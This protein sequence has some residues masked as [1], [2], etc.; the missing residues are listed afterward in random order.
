MNLILEDTKLTCDIV[1]E[2]CLISCLFHE[3][4]IYEKI[5]D[6]LKPHHFF[7][8]ANGIIYEGIIELINSG[9]EVNPIS[10]L[11]LCK[12]RVNIKN[13]K[14]YLVNIYADASF[15]NAATDYTYKIIDCYNR[16]ELLKFSHKI[17]EMAFSSDIK[18]AGEMIEDFID[19]FVENNN[20]EAESIKNI[21]DK[22]FEEM[23]SGF[24]GLTNSL[25]TGFQ[26]I[27]KCIGGLKNSSLIVVGARPAMG[28]SLFA[29]NIADYLI[30]NDVN[31]LFF[32]LE[33]SKEEIYARMLSA[34]TGI[35]SDSI[36]FGNLIGE[37]FQKV[38]NARRSISA[39]RLFVNSRPDIKIDQIR[40]Q[41]RLMKRK[42][43]IGLI[44]VDYIQLSDSNS[45]YNNNRVQAISEISR[46]LKV[47]AKELNIPVIALSQLSR[48][49]ESREDKRPQLSDLRE[50]GA[51]EQDADV[52]MFL[53]R[54]A[55]YLKN[56]EPAANSPEYPI[57]IE[58][59]AK[60][61]KQADIIIAKNRF[62]ATG[63]VKLGFDG[64][65]SRFF[66]VL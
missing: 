31:V 47:I 11:N 15:L 40:S 56:K 54:E 25:S 53:H 21:E 66:D 49:N 13:L 10:V 19:N 61:E 38:H 44:I 57:W 7:D 52:V 16:R 8:S 37:E 1:A 62:G 18:T 3:N 17:R 58:K 24:K 4:K 23:D 43:N 2:T 28:K 12:S 64:R 59:M 36:R 33:M 63:I 60:V 50:S 6:D 55:Y 45:K 48:N 27:D 42:H 29:Q 20:Q 30:K 41:S 34:V 14:E 5:E 46:G 35:A 65:G 22:F 39:S 9:V 32:S 51:I 26:N